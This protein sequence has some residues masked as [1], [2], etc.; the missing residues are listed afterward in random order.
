MKPTFDTGAP[1]IFGAEAVAGHGRL[2]AIERRYLSGRGADYKAAVIAK[3]RELGIDPAKFE[4]I[5]NPVLV[6]RLSDDATAVKV[7]SDSNADTTLKMSV[8]EQARTDAKLLPDSSKLVITENGEVNIAGSTDFVREFMR[9]MPTAARG[10]LMRPDGTLSQ[11]GVRRIQA[12]IAQKAYNDANM[13]E[14]INESLDDQGKRISAAL[15]RNAGALVALADDVKAGYRVE[16]TLASDLAMAANKYSDIKASGSTVAEY[17]AQG[18]L[19]DDGM[20]PGALEALQ[21]LVITHA[22]ARP[23]RSTFKARS[24]KSKIRAIQVKKPCFKAVQVQKNRRTDRS[25]C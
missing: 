10:D 7:A 2:T 21:V 5:E 23:C 6:R 11:A 19:V 17:M 8:A 25:A 13:I 12:A 15:V 9:S 3:A 4:R 14:R 18:R 1:T 22:A 20:T 24:R 16:N